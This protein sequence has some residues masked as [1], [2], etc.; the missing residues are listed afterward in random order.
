[1]KIGA[2]MYTIRKFCKTPEDTIKSLEK[3]AEIGYDAVHYSGC[4]PMDPKL[5]RETCDRLG[6]KIAITHNPLDRII[7]DTDALIRE[8]DILG[9]DCIG[10][11]G[12]PKEGRNNGVAIDEF[13]YSLSDAIHKIK[14]AGKKFNYHNHAFEFNMVDGQR[15]MDRIISHYDASLMGI[16]LDTYWVHQGGADVYQWID[17][18]AGRLDYIHVKDQILEEDNKTAKMA[19][20]GDGNMNYPGIFAA[21]DKAGCKYAFVEQD[22]CYDQDPFDCLARSLNYAKKLGY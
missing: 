8:H 19:P 2:Q 22:H 16:T 1:M 14:A 4:G 10:L 7:N 5:L 15:L 21:L 3:L 13:M 20:I 11:G 12:I 6:I 18:L 17:K 9:C